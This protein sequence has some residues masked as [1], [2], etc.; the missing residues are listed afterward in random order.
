MR[1]KAIG[2]IGRLRLRRSDFNSRKHRSYNH[3]SSTATKG[4]K[5]R[6]RTN[7]RLKH[8]FDLKEKTAHEELKLKRRSFLSPNQSQL[9]QINQL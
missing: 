5:R 8:E 3:K 4:R 9:V 1:I 7:L 6:K 2:W